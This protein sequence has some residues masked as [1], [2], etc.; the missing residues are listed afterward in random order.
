MNAKT[1]ME[2]LTGMNDRLG[3]VQTKDGEYKIE[4]KILMCNPILEAL[5]NAKTIRN[6]NS[7]RFGKYISLFIDNKMIV[8]ASTTSYLLE[9]IRVTSPNKEERNYH[10][11][12]QLLSASPDALINKLQLNRKP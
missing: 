4:E 5:G 7:S 9:A 1:A 3:G 12:Y 8:G 11:F 6:D 2:F 10:I